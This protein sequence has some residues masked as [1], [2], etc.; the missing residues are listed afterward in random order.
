[1]FGGPVSLE[2][3]IGAG[4]SAGPIKKP[5][6]TTLHYSGAPYLATGRMNGCAAVI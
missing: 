5:P 6:D 4:L 2:T 1:M 3:Q